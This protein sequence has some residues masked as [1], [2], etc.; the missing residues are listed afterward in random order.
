LEDL[1][2]KGQEI[3]ESLFPDVAEVYQSMVNIKVESFETDSLLLSI[4]SSH[5][6]VQ[7]TF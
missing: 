4:S 6:M 3:I 5:P 7:E 1:I 2:E